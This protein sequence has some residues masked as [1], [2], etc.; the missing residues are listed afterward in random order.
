MLVTARAIADFDRAIQ[1][2]PDYAKA[3]FR[4]GQAYAA[5]PS[6]KPM[7]SLRGP[8]SQ[9]SG[10]LGRANAWLFRLCRSRRQVRSA[11]H[12]DSLDGGQAA[13]LS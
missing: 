9:A 7:R 5:C 10:R 8:E 12:R 6:R 3:Y 13:R 4:R 11:R 1:I 2:D